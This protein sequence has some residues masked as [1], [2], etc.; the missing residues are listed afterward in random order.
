MTP[1]TPPER[2]ET[3]WNAIILLYWTGLNNL[4]PLIPLNTSVITL[5][6]TNEV[7]EI[8]QRVAKGWNDIEPG[9]YQ[10]LTKSVLRALENITKTQGRQYKVLNCALFV[11]LIHTQIIVPMCHQ[12]DLIVSP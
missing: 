3:G 5:N 12:N 7:W 10:K 6:C 1:D 11:F 2:P 4:Q 8:W 9:L